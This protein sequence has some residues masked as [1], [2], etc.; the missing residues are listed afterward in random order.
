MR[1]YAAASAVPAEKAYYVVVVSRRFTRGLLP[2]AMGQ[3]RAPRLALLRRAKRH[4][5]SDER[6]MPPLVIFYCYEYTLAT[7]P[8]QSHCHSPQAVAGKG[9]TGTHKHTGHGLT[10]WQRWQVYCRAR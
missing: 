7:H 9:G 3:A 2:S 5:E 6:C 4:I 10:G 1:Y 8:P